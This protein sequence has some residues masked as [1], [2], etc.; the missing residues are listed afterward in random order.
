MRNSAFGTVAMMRGVVGLA[1]VCEDCA[2]TIPIAVA[3]I[4]ATPIAAA[5]RTN[6]LMLRGMSASTYRAITA[7][8]CR[9]DPQRCDLHHRWRTFFGVRV[10]RQHGGDPWLGYGVRIQE[11]VKKAAA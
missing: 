3:P 9:F 5:T 6:L 4:A 1:C 10:L 8:Y 2:V 7:L 11:L